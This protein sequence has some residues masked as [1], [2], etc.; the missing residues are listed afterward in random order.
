M[1]AHALIAVVRHGVGYL[2]PHNDSDT[3]VI[4]AV[5]KDALV[6]YNFPARHTPC[7]RFVAGDEVKFPLE[8]RYCST[9]FEMRAPTSLIRFLFASSV[10]S[11]FSFK[12]LLYDVR[13]MDTISF[14]GKRISWRRPVIGT[15]AHCAKNNNIIIGKAIREIRVFIFL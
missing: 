4:L 5:G 3:S 6:E 15:V 1:L 12:K 14:S 11:L 13:L 10:D 2:M 9:A 7:V 8:A